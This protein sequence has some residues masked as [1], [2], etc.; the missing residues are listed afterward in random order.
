MCGSS[1][2]SRGTYRWMAPEM[3]KEKH[4]TK[5]VDVYSFGIVLWELLTALIPFDNM[6]PEQAAFA[7]CQKLD[8]SMPQA[9]VVSE[10]LLF[11]NNTMN[12]KLDPESLMEC[13]HDW[14]PD[15]FLSHSSQFSTH[16]SNCGQYDDG[17]E[18]MVVVQFYLTR[19][20][21][22]PYWNGPRVSHVQISRPPFVTKMSLAF[23][24]A[25]LIDAGSSNSRKTTTF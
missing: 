4:H 22:G 16:A 8:I 11:K 21:Y 24:H 2:D 9:L 3:I 6:T 15:V 19:D 14:S 17:N 20:S 5:K 12:D 25:H 23:S 1:K 7:V 13:Y 18:D 10:I